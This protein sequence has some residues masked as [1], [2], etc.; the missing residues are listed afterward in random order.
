MPFRVGGAPEKKGKNLAVYTI[1][2][3]KAPTVFFY[4][5]EPF[6]V[7]IFRIKIDIPAPVIKHH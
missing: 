6:A 3:P 5:D 4:Y 1:P 7:Y 2:C